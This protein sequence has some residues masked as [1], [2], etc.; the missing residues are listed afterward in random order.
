MR[1]P[2]NDRA[3][4]TGEKARRDAVLEESLR[5]LGIDPKSLK[6]SAPTRVLPS[7]L[8]QI[9]TITFQD[10][11]DASREGMLQKMRGAEEK[12][13]DEAH[14]IL[15]TKRGDGPGQAV[16]LMKAV[17]LADKAVVERLRPI[18]EEARR[19]V[20]DVDNENIL[21]R[22]RSPEDIGHSILMLDKLASAVDL[23]ARREEPRFVV[24]QPQKERVRKP[25]EAAALD[26]EVRSIFQELVD[27]PENIDDMLKMAKDRLATLDRSDPAVRQ[28]PARCVRLA[29]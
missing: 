24:K 3:T 9:L 6:V 23:R 27:N 8:R 29:Q 20:S 19:T 11:D 26:K 15:G 17:V 10:P 22:I 13:L 21:G 5:A 12:M 1:P 2:D 18:F 14:G 4:P 7:E 28:T 25:D 16:A